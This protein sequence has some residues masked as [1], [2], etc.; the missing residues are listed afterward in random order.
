[1]LVTTGASGAM[2]LTALALSDGEVVLATPATANPLRNLLAG[3]N[4]GQDQAP[5]SERTAI[6]PPAGRKAER[7]P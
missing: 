6:K 2:F 7:S 3:A 4:G 5:G 1:M